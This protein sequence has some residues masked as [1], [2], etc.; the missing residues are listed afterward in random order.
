[1]PLSEEEQRLL[2]EMERHLY[3]EKTDVHTPRVRSSHSPTRVIIAV[4]LSLVGLGALFAGMALTAF[5]IGLIGFVLL[6]GGVIL[7]F[8]RTGE[9]KSRK[10]P[11]AQ[12]A[13]RNDSAGSGRQPRGRS[14]GFMARLDDRWDRRGQ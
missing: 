12:S 2:D 11:S 1:M 6:L 9:G 4:S 13:R 8:S 10:N 5:V 14:R 3:G 7:G